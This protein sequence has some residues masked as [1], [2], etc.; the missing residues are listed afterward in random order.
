MAKL[1][2][3]LGIVGFVT[4]ILSIF[5]NLLP[6]VSDV[7]V[8][9]SAEDMVNEEDN[10]FDWK[11]VLV[12]IP[13]YFKPPEKTKT[14]DTSKPTPKPEPKR[15]PTEARFVAVVNLDTDKEA[16]G[17]FLIP[18]NDQPKALKVGDGWLN[19]WTIKE[20]KADYVI[21]INAENNSEIAQALF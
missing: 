5:S 6:S 2:Y 12:A 8:V 1:L 15:M 11:E 7:E 4:M 16:A 14:V 13:V 9:Q 20:L 17:M 18:G 19:Q 3:P 21:W 10:K